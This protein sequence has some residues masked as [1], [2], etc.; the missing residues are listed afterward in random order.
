MFF[1]NLSLFRFPLTLAKPLSDLEKA[2]DDCR[3]KPVGP[4]EPS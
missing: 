1:R 4:M 2:L 3:L